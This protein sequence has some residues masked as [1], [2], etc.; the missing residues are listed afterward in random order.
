MSSRTVSLVLLGFGYHKLTVL[1]YINWKNNSI[2]LYNYLS[3]VNLIW[4]SLTVEFFPDIESANEKQKFRLLTGSFT[5]GQS[6][7]FLT[8]S[9]FSKDS[10]IELAKLSNYDVELEEFTRS[11]TG[12]NK[13]RV[14]QKILHNGEV[15]KAR[16]SPH[17]PDLICSINNK[18]EIY[19]FDK[20]R[21]STTLL[22]SQGFKYDL[23]LVPKH[24]EEGF[25]L[26][27]NNNKEGLL[28][29]GS[30]DGNVKIFDLNSY[31]K[32]D[33]RELSQSM[34]LAVDE[35][36]VNDVKFNLNHD[37]V[38][39]AVGESNIIK[40]IDL[41]T[42]S[43]VKASDSSRSHH[44]SGINTL[45]FNANN[46]FCI[47]TGDSS[48]LINIWDYRN[49]ESPLRNVQGAHDDA[50]TSVAFNPEYSE[51][52]LSSGN[53]SKVKIWDLAQP[54][55]EELR[56]VH[57][58]HLLP[59]NESCWNINDPQMVASVSNDNTLHV[60]KPCL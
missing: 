49:L 30:M 59:V 38:V 16:I 39:T 51:L 25:G 8:L 52:L 23:K 4:P 26:C 9:S 55:G 41:R 1:D 35:G 17:K 56:F 54:A 15:N 33:S 29:T 31:K 22:N 14:D 50:I 34:E 42:K 48:G 3:T 20:T 6:D 46:D 37:S 44:S 11:S 13:F 36:G 45:S 10:D 24:K 2:H 5:S 57:G 53:D 28:A 32:S 47:A 18:G 21:H 27:W 40:M 58:G 12:N 7:E 19:V 43:V 60:F